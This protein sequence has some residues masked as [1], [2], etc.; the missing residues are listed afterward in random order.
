MEFFPLKVMY[1]AIGALLLVQGEVRAESGYVII[2]SQYFSTNANETICINLIELQAEVTVQL[3]NARRAYPPVAETATSGMVHGQVCLNMQVPPL[4][5]W[6][7]FTLRA[8]VVGVT[9]DGEPFSETKDTGVQLTS[10]VIKTYVQTDKPIYK[11]GQSVHI[12]ILSLRY[13]SMKPYAERYSEIYITSPDDIR[14]RQWRNV[15]TMEGLVDL[16]MRLSED[17]VLGE[18]TIHVFLD[19]RETTETFR[20]DEYVLPK[21]DVIIRPPSYIFVLDETVDVAVCGLYTYGQPVRGSISLNT[22]VERIGDPLQLSIEDTGADG[23]HKFAIRLTDLGDFDFHN[24]HLVLDVEFNETVTG[25]SRRETHESTEITNQ[26]LSLNIQGPNGF[27]PGLPYRFQ[28]SAK[29]PNGQPANDKLLGIRVMKSKGQGTFTFGKTS[30]TDKGGEIDVEFGSPFDPYITE[31]TIQVSYHHPEGQTSPV[32]SSK[33]IDAWYS[34]SG[35]FLAIKPLTPTYPVNENLEV[36]IEF[37][38]PEAEADQ[39]IVEFNYIVSANRNLITAGTHTWSTGSSEGSSTISRYV[40]IAGKGRAQES[41][42]SSRRLRTDPPDLEP[43]PDA[44]LV[45]TSIIVPVTQKMAPSVTLL[46][47]YTR[48]DGEVVSARQQINIH[49][50]FENNVTLDF[51]SGKVYPG[52]DV[53]LNIC[54]SPG[55]LCAIGSVDKSIL[56]LEDSNRVTREEVFSPMSTFGVDEQPMT[57]ACPSTTSEGRMQ[58]RSSPF[59]DPR[60]FRHPPRPRPPY[61]TSTRSWSNSQHF[62][63]LEAFKNSGVEILSNMFIETRPCYQYTETRMTYYH[64]HFYMGHGGGIGPMRRGQPGAIGPQGPMAI[65]SPDVVFSKVPVANPEVEPNS[66]PLY[67]LR[68]YFPDTWLWHLSSVS[69]E[70][71]TT[72]QHTVPHSITDWITTGFCT[73]SQ[74]GVGIA[75]PISLRVFQPFFISTTLPYSVIRDEEFPLKIT[76]FNYFTECFTVAVYLEPSS[77]FSIQ[78]GALIQYVCVCGGQADSVDFNIIPRT[79]GHIP[80]IA[81]GQYVL[82]EEESE[83]CGTPGNYT[84]KLR[85]VSDAVN[86]TVLVEAEGAELERLTSFMICTEEDD[87]TVTQEVTFEFPFNVVPDTQ[88]C[89]VQLTGNVLGPVLTNLGSLL[90]MPTGCGEQDMVRFTPNIFVLMYLD[91]TGQRGN[92][93]DVYEQAKEYMEIGYERELQYRLND[94]SYSAFG[95]RDGEGSTWLTAFVLKSF[96]LASEFIEIDQ[97]DLEVTRLWL[98]LNAQDD[99]TGCFIQ[100]GRVI[101]KEMQGGHTDGVTLTAYVTIALLEAGVPVTST[102]MF[103]SVICLFNALDDGIEDTYTLALVTY[104]LAKSEN[105]FYERGLTKLKEGAVHGGDGSIHWTRSDVPPCDGDEDTCKADPTEIE[106]TA[107]ILLLYLEVGDPELLLDARLIVKWLNKQR[108]SHEGFTST[109]DTVIGLEALAAYAESVHSDNKTVYVDISTTSGDLQSESFGVTKE[110]ELLMEECTI[111][112][113]PNTVRVDVEG[114]GCVLFQTVTQYNLPVLRLTNQY[115]DVQV[116]ARDLTFKQDCS[117]VYLDITISYQ[118]SENEFTNMAVVDVKM[119]SGYS[120]DTNEL[121]KYLD[122]LRSTGQDIGLM[123]YDHFEKGKP[124]S[125]YFNYFSRDPTSFVLVLKR[126]IYV[127]DARPAYV[128]VY[129][130]Y[131]GGVVTYELYHPCNQN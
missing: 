104:A 24:K 92:F 129:D 34:P 101:H 28:I 5:P 95:Q 54:A 131:E 41:G 30:T 93:L 122:Y 114:E 57:E 39:M 102:V 25:V 31:L 123:R 37:I 88:N 17:P 21:F 56:L 35:S 19:G 42:P 53:F 33:T 109:Q 55:S 65:P 14:V 97:R 121:E 1:V 91:R 23:C 82:P 90:R 46:L 86:K 58:K 18:W 12:R 79:L 107:Y 113:C 60:R 69:S 70:G 32:Y 75:E 116:D 45:N 110:N 29:L 71:V 50:A 9:Y 130:Y 106:M 80:I 15:D 125:L 51:N 40:N 105:H 89:K 20:L 85:G 6:G 128:K 112:Q 8:L 94:G 98:T 96:A 59:F 7:R 13:P 111:N 87:P 4:E 119:V 63:S 81:G 16:T 83:S 36:D 26:P 52:S 61:I 84:E 100:R 66:S 44:I 76:V 108:N 67:Q 77:Y 38:I 43:Y 22:T 64:R 68:T 48:G 117:R 49:L 3:V 74:H 124:F 99:D 118:D 10:E 47:Y 103:R 73:S 27:K 2:A 120:V 127:K 78:N 115:F 126:D 62:D 72:V 11:A